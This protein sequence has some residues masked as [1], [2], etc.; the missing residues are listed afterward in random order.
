MQLLYLQC[1]A[2]VTTAW[3]WPVRV[4]WDE[5]EMH[6]AQLPGSVRYDVMSWLHWGP[7]IILAYAELIVRLVLWYMN[8]E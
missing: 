3:T 4:P 8:S 2:E 7:S 1:Y 6:C 5:G